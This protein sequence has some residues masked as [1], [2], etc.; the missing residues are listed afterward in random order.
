MNIPY[1]LAACRFRPASH[2]RS[3]APL[4]IG[5][6]IHVAQPSPDPGPTTHSGPVVRRFHRCRSI[7][8]RLRPSIL[9]EDPND[10]RRSAP[11]LPAGRRNPSR[12]PRPNPRR[13]AGRKAPAPM[14]GGARN[15]TVAA[16]QL[17][18]ST[19][20]MGLFVQ[21]HIAPPVHKTAQ[22]GTRTLSAPSPQ[23]LSLQP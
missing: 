14:A 21:I 23:A 20:T 15:S 11:S 22:S 9:R 4:G 13:P 6:L 7:G 2:A 19:G 5:G 1:P 18:D 3:R 16:S 17:V 10:A 12:S 8:N